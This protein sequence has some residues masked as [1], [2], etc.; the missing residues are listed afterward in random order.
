MKNQMNKKKASEWMSRYCRL[1][2]AIEFCRKRGVDIT[3]FSRPRDIIVAC[4]CCGK[5]LSWNNVDGGHFIGRGRGGYSGVYFDERNVHAQCKGCNM[6]T[7]NNPDYR[8]FMLLKYGQD[9]IDELELRH[10]TNNYKGQIEAIGL[11]YKGMFLELKKE[12]DKLQ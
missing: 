7:Q 1:R 5:V 10:K 12:L 3:Q 2:D 11:M 8:K 6:W 9:T 4:C